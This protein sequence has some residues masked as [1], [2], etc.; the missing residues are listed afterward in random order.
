METLLA[1][2]LLVGLI[3]GGLWIQFAVAISGPVKP[4]TSRR[5]SVSR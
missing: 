2:G 4:S 1:F 3:L 5:I